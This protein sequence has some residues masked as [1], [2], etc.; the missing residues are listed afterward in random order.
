MKRFIAVLL[1]V[2]LLAG[3]AL[4][5]T[6]AA[7][8]T[9]VERAGYKA[10]SVKNKSGLIGC[11]F[12]E[13][14]DTDTLQWSDRTRIYTVSDRADTDLRNLYG[15]IAGMYDWDTCTYAV[16]DKVQFAYN[17]PEVTA[18]KSYKTLNN[19]VKYL[20]EYLEKQQ[21]VTAPA[22][23]K[24]RKTYILNT[25]TKKFHLEDCP[26]I[27]QMKKANKEKFTGKRSELIAQGYEP[28]KKCNP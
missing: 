2:A 27:K 15:E 13:G 19:Y 7:V 4:A 24:G 21:P 20:G 16:G 11:W 26:T 28:C 8:N 18:V 1:S 6:V 5:E 3:V 10:A 12:V 25:S 17:A 14:T 23:K 9:Y 22:Q